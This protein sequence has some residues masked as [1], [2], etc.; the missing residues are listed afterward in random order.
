MRFSAVQSSSPRG[1]LLLLL[2]RAMARVLHRQPLTA[3]AW[4]QSQASPGLIRGAHSG[5]E[6]RFS[7][8]F[9]DFPLSLQIWELSLLI[10]LVTGTA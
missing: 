1:L 10:G 6:T 7:L 3:Y 4:V 5:T 9:S 8:S 2:G